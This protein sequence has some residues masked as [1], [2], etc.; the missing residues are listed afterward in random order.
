MNINI[1]TSDNLEY[2][3]EKLEDV[4]FEVTG[5]SLRKQ[6]VVESDEFLKQAGYINEK[7]VDYRKAQKM[8]DDIDGKSS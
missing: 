5:K 6:H 4:Y 1:H 2:I 3:I 7:I 8:R